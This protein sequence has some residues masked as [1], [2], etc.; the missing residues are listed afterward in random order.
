KEIRYFT[1]YSQKDKE[2]PFTQLD[3]FTVPKGTVE[4]GEKAVLLM[5]SSARNVRVVYEIEH[6][7]EIIAKKHLSLKDEQRR[8]EIPITEKH[9]GNISVHLTFVKFN[10]VFRHNYTFVVPW[11]HKKL[12]ISFE[13]F[14]DKLKPGEQEEWR[15]RIGGPK[16]EEAAAEMLATLYDASLD[17]F[18]PLH[19][20]FDVF[21]NHYARYPWLTNNYFGALRTNRIGVL[22]RSSG[23]ATSTYDRLNWFGFYWRAYPA[24]H[25]RAV[26][27]QAR[28]SSAP[29]AAAMETS[30]DEL[31]Q[32]GGVRHKAKKENAEEESYA[33]DGMDVT[34]EEKVAVADPAA[35]G[36]AEA[37]DLSTVKA[38]TN[39]Q[40]TAFFQPHLRTDKDGSVVISFTVPE[41]LTKWKM[42]GF[43]HGK[44]LKY[45][46][47]SNELVTQKE[48]MVVPNAPRF[49]RE[50]DSLELSSKITNLS[51]KDLTGTAK[52]MLFDAATFQPVDAKFKNNSPEKTFKALQGQSDRVAWKIA[53]P[54]DVDTVTYRIVAKSGQFSD[55]EEKPVPILKNRML[56]TES[57]P[58]PVRSLQTKEFKFKKLIGS[59]GS[60]TLKHHK[61]TLEFTSNPVWYAV[62]ALP[63]L[64]EYPH[65]CMEQ[66]FSRYYAN[67]IAS[68]IVNS[69]PK[70]K[71]VFDIWKSSEDSNSLLSNLEKNQELKGLLLEETPWVLN[72]QNETQRKKRVALLF[73]LNK[74]AA[75]LDR[76]L[77]KLQEG[78]MPSGAWPWFVGMLE[79]RYITQHIVCGF[80]HLDRLT[81]IDSRKNGKV[82]KMLKEAVPYL[83]RKIRDDYQWLLKHEIDLDRMNIS[84]IQVHYLYARSY[85]RDIP[86]D[87][88]VTKA[89]EYY[90]GQA[91]K[92][93]LRFNRYSQGMIALGLKRYGNEPLAVAIGKSI[94]EHALYSEE[95][96]M[97]WKDSYGYYWY[98]VPIET[99]ALLIELF[100]EVMEDQKSVEELKTW[101][102]K[103]KQT[104]DWRTTKATAEAC[105]ALLLRGSEWIAESQPPEITM[106]KV[107]KIKIEPLKMDNVKVEAGSGYF[108]T[109]WSGGD[110]T[111]D[112]GH[113]TVKNNNKIVAWGSLYWQYFENLDKITPAETPLKLKKQLFVERPSD[114][115]PKLHP[116]KKGTLKIGDRVKV[117]IELRVDRTMEY[118]HMKDMRA[119]GFEPENVISRCKWQDGLC[120]YESTK[121]A[122]TNFFFARLPKGTY[123]FEYPLRV[124]HSGDFS[125]G[126]TTIQCMYAPEFSSHSEGVRVQIDQA[127]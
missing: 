1:L 51:E 26:K 48:L 7:G 95:M 39:F 60:T 91:E 59:S 25:R 124:S 53:I 106:G 72:A 2:V 28:P 23:Y 5:G 86:M 70:I 122:S 111:P 105:Y 61:L 80:A 73:D 62:Q 49:F 84:Y 93:W 108:K 58:L 52:L 69:N 29:R 109:A 18:R 30:R 76:A 47:T 65:E 14:R 67:S 92:Y 37:Q 38:R 10:R 85:F 116:I 9:R 75:Q 43:A 3:W 88:S 99:H 4:P 36:G 44:D 46:F 110:V 11:S 54:D 13:T 107:K 74:M 96:G 33:I 17:A 79:S 57:L 83:D 27:M 98:Q 89:F 16:G 56:V 104:Q 97:Y 35:G 121:D 41:A 32:V 102:L 55:G 119:S 21:P 6:R 66:V 8:I 19:W 103:Q 94:K 81:V 112:M 78:Q 117:R 101:L 126:I 115:G 118:V 15:L 120:Y 100:D 20:F 87:D 64:M 12:A 90:K 82:W 22:Q 114:T 45:G 42:M 50:G 113:I 71:R 34:M 68:F 40:E 31:R 125:N 127:H 63:Y 123:V 77:R 24:R